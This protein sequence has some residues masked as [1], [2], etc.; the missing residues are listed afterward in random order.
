MFLSDVSVRRPIAMSCLIIGLTLLGLNASRKMGQEMMPKL[1]MPYITIVT[2]YPGASPEQIE[3]DIAKRIEDQMVT[4]DGL[5]HVSS[6][7]ME[8]ICLSHLDFNLEVNVDIAATAVRVK[9]DLFR[10]DCP[11]DVEDPKIM[12]FD[13]NAMP[14]VTMALTGEAS[15]DELDDYADN[16]LRDRIT[17]ISGVADVDLIGGAE[18]EVHVMLDRQKL[19][20]RG[21]SSLHVVKAIREEIGTI[22]SGHIKEHG[23]EFSVKLD[24]EYKNV[25]DIA[26]L[27]INNE[28]GQRC[29]ISNVGYVEMT[30]EELRQKAAIDGRPCVAIKIVK[31]A[32][33]NAVRVVNHVRDAMTQLERE[34]PGGMELV[35]VSDD[36]RF[37]EASVQ[38]AWINVGQGIILT[39]LVLFFFL[40]N[41]RSTLVIGITMP[42]TI[43]IGMFFMQFLDYTLNTSTLIAMGLSVGILVTNSIVVMEAIVKRVD[44]TGDVKESARLGSSEV[45][46]AV[47]ASVSTN[48]VVLFPIAMMGSVIGLFLRPLA[49]T[50]VI[51]TV[52]SLFISFTLTPMLCS[53]LLKPKQG[54][55]TSLLGKMESRW[56]RLFDRILNG[57][58]KM[59]LYNEQN[60][61]IA[62]LVLVAVVFLFFHSLSLAKK[63]GFSFFTDPDRGQILVILEYPTRYNL[64]QTEQR[65][66]QVEDR[67][68]DVPELKHVLTTIGKV[69]GIIGQASEGVYLAQILLTFSERD[70]RKLTIHDIQTKVRSC[71]A[72]YPECIVTV[73]MAKIIGGQ[74]S[75]IE[76]EIAGED[77]SIL[78]QLALKSKEFVDHADGFSDSDTTVRM[79]KPELR[80]YPQ[81]A[82]LADLGIPATGLGLVL[83][84]NLEGIKAGTFKKGAR[85]Y[86]IVVELIEEE[87]K[88]Q[89]Q[90]FLF[91][92]AP[93]HALLLTNLAEVE[94]RLIPI[95]ITRKDKRRISKL[96]TN[97]KS[98]KPLG[99]A[100]DEIGLALDKQGDLPPGY[101]YFFA[102]STE[103]MKEAQ[104]EFKEASMIAIILVILTLAG[105]LESFRQPWLILITIPLALMGVFWALSMTGKSLSMFVIMGIV[106]MTGIVVNNAILIM[107]QFNTHIKEGLPRHK[108][109][110]A[111][112]TERFRPIVMITVAAILG[113]M[114]LAVG[115]GIGAEM[116][117][118]VGIASIGGIAISGVLTLVVLPIV[119]DLFTRR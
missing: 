53:V 7:C 12:K 98:G 96:L 59:L 87:G 103:R 70:E 15:I 6:S 75:D 97:I 73:N 119:Y 71:L 31:K 40:Y 37:I 32:E 14:V 2:I 21:L 86:D 55:S 117:N 89:I 90:E 95:Q 56:N 9:L 11:Q 50:M 46:V 54:N 58:R 78:D 84:A 61:R 17:V 52:V 100:V 63:V 68:K 81:R 113:M 82:V 44:K 24:A 83:R 47:L 34:L 30:T 33:A 22:P 49:L 110:V 69:E 101:E 39:A 48:V 3:T 62:I 20:A 74:A 92:G 43:I 13:I 104:S 79:G 36:G 66:H 99:T 76:M 19:A 114:P 106:M 16:T 60:K 115:Q 109:M 118:G 80:V 93:G 105:I 102:G 94:E 64:S 41:F 45:A 27:E 72:D 57:Y 10:A 77:L 85:N 42:L 8:I 112:A 38:S 107:D 111:A 91:P 18:R 51:M 25:K 29:Y 28:Q 88:K 67:L 5:K 108:A 23:T 65:A 116:R 35:W 26:S 4:I 1:D